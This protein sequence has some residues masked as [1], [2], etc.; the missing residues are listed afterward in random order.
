[1]HPSPSSQSAAVAQGI[2]LQVASMTTCSQSPKDE[3]LSHVHAS[4]SW[5]SAAFVHFCAT[6]PAMGE[7]LHVPFRQASAVQGFPSEQSPACVHGPGHPVMGTLRQTL[8]EQTSEVQ[9][10]WSS[11]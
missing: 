9:G 4:V 5:Q 6:Q 8:P 2:P 7:A 1:M 3:H 11:H 10:F